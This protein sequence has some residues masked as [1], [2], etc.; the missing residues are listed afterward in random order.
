LAQQRPAYQQAAFWLTIILVTWNIKG[1]HMKRNFT[2]L[3]PVAGLILLTASAQAQRPGGFGGPGGFQPTP[4]MQAKFQAWRT[5]ND[6]H[7]N[8][9]ALERTVGGLAALEQ[10]PHTKLNK[11]QARAV[12]AVIKKWQSKPAL[13]D[14]QAR[15]V[16][17]Q[18]THPLTP[19]QLKK[20]AAFH[21]HRGGFGGGRRGP[22][23]PTPGGPG[24]THGPGSPGGRPGGFG[25]GNRLG[26]FGG[27]RAAFDPKSMPAPHDYNPL[28]PNTQPMARRR[29]QDKQRFA[30]LMAA[31]LAAAK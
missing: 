12:L 10:D 31:L 1:K 8:V 20:I 26:G 25:G 23:G 29:D 24:G 28:N 22:G 5:W 3:L 27:G 9:A 15:L 18:L 4:A 30:E 2:F 13:N 6:N 17:T 14:V 7:K 11:P 16:N 21:Q 19:V